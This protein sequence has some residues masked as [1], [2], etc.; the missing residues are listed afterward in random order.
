MLCFSSIRGLGTPNPVFSNYFTFIHR[1][2]RAA[3]KIRRRLFEL[4]AA[5]LIWQAA[6]C[7]WAEVLFCA[8]V[9][10]ELVSWAVCQNYLTS[11]DHK[12]CLW[13]SWE[14]GELQEWFM[15]RRWQFD[16]SCLGAATSGKL[17][18]TSRR[19][20]ITSCEILF[21][22]KYARGEQKK[23]HKPEFYLLLTI[24]CNTRCFV[25]WNHLVWGS[26]SCSW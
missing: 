18:E 22:F 24:E 1:L 9:S 23:A 8:P 6:L 21:L 16:P 14:K 15:N 10:R 3:L 5:L 26:C 25:H 12:M 13:E 17:Y 7:L 19:A 20:F 11:K 4:I 2:R